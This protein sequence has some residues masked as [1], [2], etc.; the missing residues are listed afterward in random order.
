MTKELYIQMAQEFGDPTDLDALPPDYMDFPSYVHSAM[1]IFNALP[2]TYTSTMEN[3]IY[4]G[5]DYASLPIL[6][7][8]YQIDQ[9]DKRLVFDV[10]QFID[11][12]TRKKA[13]D[14]V[15]KKAKKP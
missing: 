13:I 10:L 15:N 2:D 3:I 6:F 1:L 11:S 4:T 9:D 8:L 5:K 12:R 7:E 14:A